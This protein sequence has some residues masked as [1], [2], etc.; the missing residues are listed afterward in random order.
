MPGPNL[1]QRAAR[2]AL[3]GPGLAARRGG[4]SAFQQDQ[5]LVEPPR[6]MPMPRPGGETVGMPRGLPGLI[7]FGP[8]PPGFAQASRFTGGNVPSPFSPTRG[9]EIPQ[10]KQPDYAAP[11]APGQASALAP[12]LAALASAAPAAPTGATAGGSPFL[13]PKPAP[14][15]S[16][17]LP[18]PSLPSSPAPIGT[19]TAIGAP[20]GGQGGGGYAPTPAPLQS[21]LIAALAQQ[22][23]KL[24][25][26]VRYV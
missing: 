21:A 24:R 26:G 18:Q 15:T 10:F 16:G 17:P 2:S 19:P 3:G 8:S 4:P 9:E 20:T 7:G 11:Q 13:P 25:P 1:F 23:Q 12:L 5:Q 22:G 14:P 6:P